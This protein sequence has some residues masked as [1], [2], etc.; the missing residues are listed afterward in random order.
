MK[1]IVVKASHIVGNASFDNYEEI[2]SYLKQQLDLYKKIVYSSDSVKDAKADKKTLTQLKKSIDDKRK[3]IKKEYME[4][5]LLL[6]DKVKELISLIDEPLALINNYLTEQEQKEKEEKRAVIKAFYNNEA[7]CLGEYADNLFNSPK[8]FDISWLNKS[9]KDQKWQDDI[10]EK[11]AKATADIN[12]ICQ[13][14]E[15]HRGALISKYI[16]TLDMISVNA[17]K[18]TLSNLDG[19]VGGAEE[20][21]E[22]I[23][24][25]YKVLKIHGT[26][27]QMTRILEQMNLMGME[28][29]ELE[30]GM[31]KDFEEL[32]EPSFDSFV[33][34][35]IET[36]GTYGAGYGDAPAE[37]TEIGAVKVIGRKIV[38]RFSELC[39]PG[40]SITPMIER[41]THIT[42]DMVKNKPSVSEIISKFAEFTEGMTLVG[43][44]I[45]GSDLH[46]ISTAAKRA[47]V[48]MGNKFFD[49]Y[50]Y[51]KK[52]KREKSWTSLKLDYLSN[53]FGIAQPNA[54][55]AWCD[56]EANVGVYLEL[57][58]MDK[59][60]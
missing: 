4:P 20:S 12:S 23:T 24:I 28:Y 7:C 40:R 55:R 16:E 56:A 58:N 17:Y 36:T 48:K 42:N 60:N 39:N 34:F 49:T 10:K 9:T 14:E 8:F 27:R 57:K 38:A 2:K 54:H 59:N 1:D 46:Y 50:L 45:K 6:E 32:T 18:K 15:S 41:I 33:A 43:H 25:G 3:E 19:Y 21:D 5:Y 22:D 52:F 47:G 37:I 26:K 29:D 35:D 44:N 31:P 53:F 11:I 51:A 30:D 13:N